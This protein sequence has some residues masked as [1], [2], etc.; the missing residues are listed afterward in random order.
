MYIFVFPVSQNE[1]VSKQNKIFGKNIMHINSL[2]KTKQNSIEGCLGG[3]VGEVSAFSSG[4]DPRVL[5]AS[6]A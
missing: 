6:L 1:N 3:S 5:E 2:F 4:H